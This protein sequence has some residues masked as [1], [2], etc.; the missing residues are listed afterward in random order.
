MNVFIILVQILQFF[1]ISKFTAERLLAT[2]G[3]ALCWCRLPGPEMRLADKEEEEGEEQEEEPLRQ[4]VAAGRWPPT[5]PPGGTSPPSPRF[6][7]ISAPHLP[8][9]QFPP[10]PRTAKVD[11]QLLLQFRRA[12]A[13]ATA[14]DEILRRKK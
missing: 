7:R 12:P 4:L 5:S 6:P 2:P 3:V 9:H 14:A 13:T 1:Q 10:A 11:L 8:E